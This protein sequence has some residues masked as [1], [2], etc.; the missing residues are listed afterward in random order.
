MKRVFY[1]D[2]DRFNRRWLKALIAA[3]LI[4]EGDVWCDS[5]EYITE[6][7]VRDH[8]HC[9][10]FAGIGGWA[11]ALELA[12]WPLNKKV[13]TGSCPCQPFSTAG[14]RKG[15]EDERHLWPTWFELIKECR[16]PTI[17]GEQVASTLGRKWLAGIRADLETLGYAVGAADLC[18]ASVGAPHTR[19]RLFWVAYSTSLRKRCKSQLGSKRI[20]QWPI[21]STSTAYWSN[22][23]SIEDTKGKKRRIEPGTFPLVNGLPYR[24]VYQHGYGNAIVPQVAAT[25]IQA[26]MEAM[27]EVG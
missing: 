17:F 21:R 5:V 18:A 8:D 9:H 3:K 10:F 22:F 23:E 26:S 24:L 16:P 12:G 6:L 13:W 11:Y 7:M 2:I 20:M 4:P 27:E 19:Q 14:Q 15:D 25:F 1:N